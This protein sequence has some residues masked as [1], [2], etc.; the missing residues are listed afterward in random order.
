MINNTQISACLIV[1]NEEKMLPGCL[2]S[3]IGYTHE[4]IIV[5]TGSD[6]STIK[7]AMKWACQNNQQTHFKL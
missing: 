3:L 7:I 4:I 6:D 2:E 5:N 1:K